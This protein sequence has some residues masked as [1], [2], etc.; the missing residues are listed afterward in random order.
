MIFK[1]R[2]DL[3]LHMKLTYTPA[4]RARHKIVKT[5]IDGE[6]KGWQAVLIS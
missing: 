5:Y 2:S 4:L 3:V 6:F 1:S